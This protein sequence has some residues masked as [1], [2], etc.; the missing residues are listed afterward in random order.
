[1]EGEI[2][3]DKGVLSDNLR[4]EKKED[5]VLNRLNEYRQDRIPAFEKHM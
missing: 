2:D 5:T 3:S 1:M 4:A